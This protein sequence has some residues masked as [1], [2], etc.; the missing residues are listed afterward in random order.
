MKMEMFI[1]FILFVYSQ[2]ITFNRS[3]VNYNHNQKKSIYLANRNYKSI[4]FLNWFCKKIGIKE[5]KILN[6]YYSIFFIVNY[7]YLD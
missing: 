7:N 6:N 3:E 4:I 2:T 5:A 1:I